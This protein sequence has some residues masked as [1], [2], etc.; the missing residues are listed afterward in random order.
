MERFEVGVVGAGVHGASAT[1]HLASRG[2]GAVV[3]ERG[4]PAS[5]PT[6]FSSGICRAYYTNDFLAGVARD[7]IRMFERFEE[8]TGVD[9]GH[10]RTGLYYLHPEEDA[11][12]ARASV[13]RLNALGIPTDLYEG[14]EL[15]TRLSGFELEGIA[16]GAYEREAG[17][18][19]PHATTEGFMRKAVELGA[20]VRL[21]TSVIGLEPDPS[22]G[23]V[24]RTGE[25]DGIACERILLAAGPWTRPLGRMVGVDLPLT[26]ER[27]IVATMRWASAERVPGFGDVLRGIYM[28]P[29]GDDLFLLGPLTPA[30]QVDPDDFTTSITPEEVEDL[31]RRLTARVPGLGSAEVHGGWASLYDVS[32][33]WQPVIGQIAPGVFVD[34]GTS[35]HGF[36]LAPALGGHVADLVMSGTPAPG[37]AAFGPD[38]FREGHDL[39]AGFGESRILG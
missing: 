10:R 9:A 34:A 1:F 11:A 7:S 35:G 37:L 2:V 36:K 8:L 30:S 19:D 15:A 24:L 4:T 33:D 39:A 20:E 29:E 12:E 25:G 16:L 13:S 6:G 17:Y 32:P 21:H 31:A 22:G 14:A 27:H 5:G 23:W 28:R 26:V 3:V 38:R 18:A